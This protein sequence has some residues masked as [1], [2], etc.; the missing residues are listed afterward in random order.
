MKDVEII[1][2]PRW[3]DYTFERDLTTKSGAWGEVFADVSVDKI[4]RSTLDQWVFLVLTE[5]YKSFSTPRWPISI[6]PRTQKI[7]EI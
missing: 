3:E 2:V 7:S 1:E 6:S 4:V 5:S